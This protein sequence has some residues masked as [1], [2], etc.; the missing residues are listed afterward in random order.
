MLVDLDGVATTEGD[1][2]PALTGEVGEDALAADFAA[3]ARRAGGDLGARLAT[4]AFGRPKIEGEQGAAHKVGLAGEELEGLRHLDRG[5]EVDGSG[6]D[7]GGVAGVHIAG[8]G[9]GEDAGEA[10][11]SDRSPGRMFM[12]AA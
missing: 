10:R 12:V 3:G 4:L 6:E 7:A 11:G 5:G 1:V 2:G 9:L 8:G